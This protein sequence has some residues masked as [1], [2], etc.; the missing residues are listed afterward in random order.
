M[1]TRSTP[2]PMIRR[3]I[4]AVVTTWRRSPGLVAGLVLMSL[5]IVGAVFAPLLSIHSP[6][7]VRP[8]ERF[9]DPGPQHWFGTDNVGRDVWARSLF[10]ARASLITA[11]S[12]VVI[13]AGVG[14]PLGLV[15]GYFG[16]WADAVIMRAI[17]VQLAI[18]VIL[19]ALIV[20]MLVGRG[21]FGL[22]V[23]IGVGS[24]PNFAR[25]AR[26]S[27]MSI[28]QEEYVVAVTA[29]GAG[30]TWTIFRT[31]L[32][33]AFGPLIVQ[34][35]VTAAVAILL[36]AALSFLGM[37][38]TPPSPSWGDMLRVGKS[39]LREAP[40]FSL[41]P[42]IM[43]SITVIALDLIGRGMQQ[44]RGTSASASSDLLGRT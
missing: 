34:V 1:A 11:V 9:A 22:V 37:G 39:Y 33:N 32:P 27:T 18:P 5:I 38:A 13:A 25:V 10:A 17:D 44:L 26:A 14:V 42:G 20:V 41:V 15:S 31:I 43:L 28:K 2:L 35:V 7:F 24:I 3:T 4:T 30:H 40:W 23:A 36:E 29:M 8:F 21:H 16:R 19:L 12:A 6:Y